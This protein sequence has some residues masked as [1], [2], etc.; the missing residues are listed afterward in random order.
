MTLSPELLKALI[1]SLLTQ[2]ATEGTTI[3]EPATVQITQEQ[4]AALL[5]N[6]ASPN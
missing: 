2:K 6:Q 1:P 5:A 4:L 3:Q